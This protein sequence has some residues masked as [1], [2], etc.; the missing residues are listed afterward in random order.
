M[1]VKQICKIEGYETIRTGYYVSAD[2]RVF[3]LCDCHGNDVDQ[4][5]R[6]ELKQ[7]E[8]SGGYL[9]VALVENSGHVKYI[10]VNRLV[11]SAFVSGKT[12]EKKYVNH[13]DKNRKNNCCE[14]LEWV[15]PH[16]NNMHS[17][18]KFVYQYT[19]EG[20]LVREYWAVSETKKDGFNVSHVA[21]V[22]R[23]IEKSHKGYY[24][25]YEP[26]TKSQV[27]QRLSKTYKHLY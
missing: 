1:R 22:C 3:S 7:Y 11:A 21:N 27:L 20:D 4:S 2:G 5:K 15:T 17:L 26:L 9:N 16:G 8:K 23:G 19:K 13:I 18:S 6:R 14:N 10:R 12:D 24:F 25:S